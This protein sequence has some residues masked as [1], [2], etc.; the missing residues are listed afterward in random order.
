MR[1]SGKPGLVLGLAGMVVAL[2]C[3]RPETQEVV[4]GGSVEGLTATMQVEASGDVAQLTLHVTNSTSAPIE[5]EFSSGQRYDFRVTTE[6][7]ETLWT[8]SA[9]K[10]FMQAL[11]TETLEAGGTV[12]FSESWAAGGRRGRF[13]AV[14]QLTS[15]SHPAM[16]SVYF[17][18][19]GGE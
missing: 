18:L 9:D 1:G 10:S 13:I 6:S 12:R 2:G 16:Q 7:G 4:M 19:T 17:E 11:G 15:T 8:W 3:S 14:G 5:L